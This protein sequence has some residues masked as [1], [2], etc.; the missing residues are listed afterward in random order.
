MPMSRSQLIS[1][2]ATPHY[3]VVPRCVQGQYLY[4]VDLQTGRDF[5]HRRDW[6]RTRIFELA[7]AF[8]IDVCAYAVMS[9]HCHLVLLVDQAR[10][11]WAGTIAK[12]HDA[13]KK[14]RRRR[15]TF[16]SAVGGGGPRCRRRQAR[17]YSRQ[18]AVDPR[19]LEDR[20]RVLCKIQQPERKDSFWQLHW[21]CRGDARLGR[22]LRK[23]LPQP[24]FF[25]TGS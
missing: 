8:V 13:G 10:A 6:I 25:T 16:Q 3:H 9:N 23:I 2:N 1:L 12:L 14:L 20:S 21:P 11:R 22:A 19:A 7:D 17:E 5:T 15:A 24:T 18:L 4:G